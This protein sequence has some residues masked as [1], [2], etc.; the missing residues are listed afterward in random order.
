MEQRTG[1]T[2]ELRSAPGV[3]G[4]LVTSEGTDGT[5]D[6][7]EEPRSAPGVPESLSLQRAL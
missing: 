1:Q 6:W 2:E 7:T 5:E 3:P 4:V